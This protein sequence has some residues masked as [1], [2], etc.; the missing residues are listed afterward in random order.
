[1]LRSVAAAVA[2][3]AAAA[4]AAAAATIAKTS[5]AFLHSLH[6]DIGYSSWMKLIGL[7]SCH[8]ERRFLFNCIPM[9]LQLETYLAVRYCRGEGSL[10]L[11]VS[12]CG[13]VG[14]MPARAKLVFIDIYSLPGI[15][16]T[17]STRNCSESCQ[18]SCDLYA[19][20][21]LSLCCHSVN[22]LVAHGSVAR[23]ISK[24]CRPDVDLIAGRLPC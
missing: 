14:R 6:A 7:L 3:V 21:R 19:F 4:V 5:I 17:T 24:T 18:G 11:V 1:M 10:I 2:T 9:E 22:V 16:A 8:S 15:H 23:F 20:G 12:H 13:R